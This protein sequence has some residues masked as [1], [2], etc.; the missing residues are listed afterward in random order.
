MDNPIAHSTEIPTTPDGCKPVPHKMS[1]GRFLPPLTTRASSGIV[2]TTE[3]LLMVFSRLCRI[4]SM[5]E[6]N[7]APRLP[8][9]RSARV[10]KI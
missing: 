4:L 9:V 6:P 5:P 3:Y 1:V 8:L 2:L 7:I 10:Y